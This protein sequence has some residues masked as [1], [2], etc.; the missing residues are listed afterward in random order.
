M[1]LRGERCVM[2]PEVWRDVPGY[3]GKYQVSSEGRVRR[4]LE[5]GRIQMKTPYAIAK[6]SHSAFRIGL[7]DGGKVKW[8]YVL[9]LVAMAFL[10]AKTLE[11]KYVVHRNGL[12][13]DNSLYNIRVMSPDRCG[14]RHGGNLRKAVCMVNKDG[15]VLE[16]FPSVSA[17][18]IA[19][20]HRRETIAN[21]CNQP[22]FKPLKDGI[23]FTW[24]R[25]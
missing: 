10:P 11:G 15:D 6:G 23:S 13:S 19:T 18:S 9:R 7:W 2:G 12:H 5:D 24:D 25:R 8:F 20:R 14:T 4:L 22:G 17:A 1:D 21:R 16:I 3:E